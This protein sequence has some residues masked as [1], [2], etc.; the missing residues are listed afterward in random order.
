[1]K[2]TRAPHTPSN[3]RVLV[4]HRVMRLHG[5]NMVES[6]ATTSSQELWFLLQERSYVDCSYKDCSVYKLCWV[7]QIHIFRIHTH[8]HIIYIYIYTYMYTW[9]TMSL[10][11]HSTGSWLESAC[12][13]PVGS[14]GVHV[15]L[16]VCKLTHATPPSWG[17]GGGFMI[18][19]MAE[20]SF[21][22][23]LEL[24][25]WNTLQPGNS[26]TCW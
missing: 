17:V 20:Q 15:V 7:I 12:R 8:I 5:Q 19:V 2:P 6:S 3:Q 21:S 14:S 23:M 10:T 4:V 18:P 11:R 22:G 25:Q 16:N 1:M 9:S 24:G 13:S 26:A